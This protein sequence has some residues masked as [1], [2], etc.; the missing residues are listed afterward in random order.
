MNILKLKNE[1]AAKYMH[2][3]RGREKH[4]H[5]EMEIRYSKTVPLFIM[6]K[7]NSKRG[8]SVLKDFVFI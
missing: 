7:P 1:Y 3:K 8:F 5:L 6:D 2:H 4:L